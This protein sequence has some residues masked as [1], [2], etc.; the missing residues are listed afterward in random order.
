M[1]IPGEVQGDIVPLTA[2][3]K[4]HFGFKKVERKPDE[5]ISEFGKALQDAFYRVNDLQL[6]SDRLTTALAVRPDSVDIHDVTIAA[7]QAR[8]SL[9]FTKSI[10]DR[11]TQAYRELSNLR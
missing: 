2:T 8:L 7:E 3:N 1:F 9:L 5:F 4:M 11:I 6:E 10:V